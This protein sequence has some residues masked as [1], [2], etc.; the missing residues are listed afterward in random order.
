MYTFLI[1]IVILVLGYVFYG[2]FIEKLFKPDDRITPAYASTDGVDY[3]PMKENWRVFLI[4]L[5][6]IAGLGP[7]YGAILGALWG[8]SVYIWIVFGTIFGGG[9][10]DY[11]T[12]MISMRNNG[13]SVSESVNRYMGNKMKWLM[14]VV[15]FVLLVLVGTVFISGPAALLAKL[16]PDFMTLNV[17]LYIILVYYLIAT[18]FPFDQIIGKLYP[19]FGFALFFMAIGIAVMLVLTHSSSPLPELTSIQWVNVNN[20][21]LWPM[22]FVTVACGAVSGFHATQS[23]M[24][25][26]VIT[27][28]RHGRKI[29]YG[30]MVAEG[31]IALVWAAA[32]TSFY[33]GAP[34]LTTAL[35]DL[36][37]QGGVVF[38]IS[39]KLLGSF[40]GVL[41]MLGV[42]AAP[43]TTGDTAFRAA[44]LTLADALKMDQKPLKNRLMLS[45]PLLFIGWALT[46]GVNY[47]II[48][49]YFSWTN[50]TLAAISLWMATTYLVKNKINYWPAVL[51]AIFMTA[52]SATYILQAPEGFSLAT[53]ISYP[54]GL[55]IALGIT[56]LFF[57]KI[58][59]NK[60]AKAV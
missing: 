13:E 54:V 23:P 4:Q 12:G 45:I 10:H 21:P 22:M 50:Q 2:A 9:V 49:R 52:V 7:I 35:A 57:Y 58:V 6:N 41:A 33:Q 40:G 53:S 18:V 29:F 8:P 39:F 27:S 14:R 3:V 55:V 20:L 30:A 32:G 11:L 51:P 24:V 26:R 56:A 46:Q 59:F 34:G 17:W 37:G 60:E 15:S 48:W 28:E 43:I 47:Q 38:D 19:V 31:F 36:G 25:A 42:I 1:S 44:R 5:L 16:T